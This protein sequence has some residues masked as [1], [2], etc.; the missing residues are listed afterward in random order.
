MPNHLYNNK[1]IAKH[2]INAI[3]SSN[4]AD[5]EIPPLAGA[6]AFKSLFVNRQTGGWTQRQ[7]MEFHEASIDAAIAAAILTDANIQGAATLNDIRDI[8][9]AASAAAGGELT[10]TSQSGNRQWS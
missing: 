10:R 8:V 6:Q 5:A 1:E 7:D 3:N 4:I 9:I 2:T